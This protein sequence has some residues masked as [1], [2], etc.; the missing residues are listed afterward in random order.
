VHQLPPT[1]ERPRATLRARLERL[2]YGASN[3]LAIYLPP[4]LM[5]VLA[6]L[7]YWLVRITPPVLP[8][9]P[10]RPVRH[11]PDYFLRNFSIKSYGPEGE[12]KSEITG[13]QGRHYQDTDVLDIDNARIRS[14][15]RNGRLV[16]A[17]ARRAL[18]NGDGSE[19]QLVGDAVL[20]RE[21]AKDA[22]GRDMPR[23]EF[24]SEFLHAMLNT[25]RVRSHKPV[26]LIR[27]A[28][29]F[30]ADSLAYDNLERVAQ[31]TGR[32]RATVAPRK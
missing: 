29:R 6:L 17:T 20:V 2:A 13:S 31:M 23:M 3:M 4:M 24:R 5:A 19:V 15:D 7:T 11:A 32:V 30:T 26:T 9:E 27:G 8:P 16:V 18:S 25:E 28:D 1:P 21:A 22:A 14:F 10:E 12:L